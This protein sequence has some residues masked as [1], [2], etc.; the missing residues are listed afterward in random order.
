MFYVFLIDPRRRM[1]GESAREGRKREGD[2]K[3]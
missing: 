1:R 2:E 3:N